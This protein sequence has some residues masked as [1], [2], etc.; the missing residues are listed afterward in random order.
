MARRIHSIW[1]VLILVLVLFWQHASAQTSALREYE[2]KAA[3]LYQFANYT[4]W[5]PDAFADK[6]APFIFGILGENPIS[7]ILNGLTNK[8]V[9]GRAILVKKCSR[10][11]EAR[12]CHLLFIGSSE[13]NN[14]TAILGSLKTR[15]ILTVADTDSFLDSGG[16]IHLITANNRVGFEINLAAA[17]EAKLKIS[18]EVLRLAKKIRS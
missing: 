9:G 14:L 15:S 6:N 4:E 17:E 2:I 10:W 13:K 8:F 11:D 5:P 1:A 3:F 7:D 18:P 12:D 16:I